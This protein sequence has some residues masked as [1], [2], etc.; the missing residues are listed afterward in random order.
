MSQTN[1]R[2]H[3]LQVASWRAPEPRP[4]LGAFAQT[5]AV[6]AIEKRVVSAPHRANMDLRE[7]IHI[8]RTE[9]QLFVQR[10][11]GAIGY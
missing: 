3:G 2:E 10:M 8:V 1:V 7:E 5:L 11:A 6:S 4:R 9:K